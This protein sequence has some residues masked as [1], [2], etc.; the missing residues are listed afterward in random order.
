MHKVLVSYHAVKLLSLAIL[1]LA[2]RFLLLLSKLKWMMVTLMM[3]CMAVFGEQYEDRWFYVSRLLNNDQELADVQELVR[4]AGKVKLNGMLFACGVEGYAT[5]IPERKVRLAKLKKTCDENGVEIIP[6]IWSIGYGTMLAHNPNYVEGLLTKDMPYVVKGNK[7]YVLEEKGAHAGNFD[8]EKHDGNVFAIKGWTD[9]AGQRSFAD[10]EVKH[11]GE[12]SVRLEKFAEDKHGH[13]RV[14]IEV[15]LKPN[16]R[17][18]MKLFAKSEGLIPSKGP[19]KMQFYRMDGSQVGAIE[20]DIEPTQDWKEYSFTFFSGDST[21]ETDGVAGVS[22]VIRRPGTPF[23]VKNAATGQIYEEGKDYAKVEGLK[24]LS[25]ARKESL[26]LD[27]PE[28]SAIKDGD[29]LL[30]SFY[31]PARAGTWQYSTCM[32][33]P[34]LYDEFRTSAKAIMEALNPRKWFLSMDEVRAGGTCAACEARHTDMAHILGDCI[35]KQYQIIKE[36]RPDADVYIWSDMLDPNH[37]AHDKYYNCKGTFEGSWNYIPKDLIISC[38]YHERRNL[39]MPFFEK[40]GFRT[41]GA[42]YY[43]TDNL[44]SCR[45]WLETCNNT[46]NCTGIMYTS[47]RRKYTLLA[48][49]GELVQ[50]Y[51][52]PKK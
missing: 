39:S 11:G 38:W 16:R 14:C 26:V 43:D 51:S 2:M 32:S 5:W 9:A 45:D 8:F 7:A 3:A 52:E 24:K 10:T 15:Q 48:G 50:K 29:N 46:K 22:D 37:N 44:D 13:G 31:Q 42:A 17:Y 49:F 1:T 12:C 20:P 21:L 34:I 27:L 41:Q 18:R 36:V 4:T 19:F 35:T 33:E 47:W 28:G 6:I 25:N 30:I 40:Q 23:T